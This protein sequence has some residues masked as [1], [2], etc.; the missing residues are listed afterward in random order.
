MPL[1][2][3]ITQGTQ[4]DCSKADLLIEGIS[5]DYLLADKGYD[6]GHILEQTE[7]QGMEPVIPPRKNRTAQSAY[8]KNPYKLSHL[9]E[10]AFLY[11]KH[12]RAIATR[13]A[14]NTAS[15]LLFISDV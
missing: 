13:Y 8:D 2:V 15:R 1:K 11:L 4:A 6:A 12:W 7:K 3:F 9:V 14:E 5:A 10:N